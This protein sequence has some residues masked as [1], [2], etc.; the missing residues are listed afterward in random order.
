MSHWLLGIVVYVALASATSIPLWLRLLR[1][2]K[3]N[4]AGSSFEESPVFSQQAKARLTQHYSRMLGTLGFWKKQAEFYRYLH[5]YTMCWTI[6]SSVIIPFLVQAP[7][8]DPTLSKWLITLISGFTAIL[9]SFHRALKVDANFKA[10]RYGESEFYDAY[11]R[12]L[13]RPESFGKT[14]D[15]QLQGYF[16][17]VESVRKYIRNAEIDNL[18]TIEQVKTQL[19]DGPLSKGNTGKPQ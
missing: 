2:V 13:D 18:P 19:E 7:S 16:D 10:F 5:Y 6:P 4:P 12:L 9:L 11:R 17:V 3:L 14:E 15:E 8:N 1:G